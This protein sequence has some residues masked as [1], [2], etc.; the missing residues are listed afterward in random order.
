MALGA[1]RSTVIRHVMLQTLIPVT[2]GVA[3]GYACIWY[4]QRFVTALL[5]G[6]SALDPLMLI[7]APLLL[8]A[9]ALLAT[10]APARR[11]ARIQPVMALRNE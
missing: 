2:A 11:A 8:I 5:Y 9:M 7:G 3:V 1:T 4:L 10:Y 6:V